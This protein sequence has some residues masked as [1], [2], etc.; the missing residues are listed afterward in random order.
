[1]VLGTT[2]TEYKLKMYMQRDRRKEGHPES[3]NILMMVFLVEMTCET[4][5][6]CEWTKNK[7]EEGKSF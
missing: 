7:M 4:L 3:T 1:M 2:L 6:K 5:S